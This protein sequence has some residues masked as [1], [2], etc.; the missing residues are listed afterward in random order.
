MRKV[1]ICD[2]AWKTRVRCLTPFRELNICGYLVRAWFFWYKLR[3]PLVGKT[4]A[5][6]IILGWVRFVDCL[7]FGMYKVHHCNLLSSL[8]YIVSSFPLENTWW[9]RFSILKLSWVDLD[10]DM[11]KSLCKGLVV[12]LLLK[13]L[14]LLKKSQRLQAMKKGWHFFLKWLWFRERERDGF[15]V[16]YLYLLVYNFH[17]K[18]CLV[19]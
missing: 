3:G 4:F 16:A 1:F 19:R 5:L 15:A 10:F 17:L 9:Q 18:T 7:G 12:Y 2:C 14:A 8:C 6:E 11:A 13:R